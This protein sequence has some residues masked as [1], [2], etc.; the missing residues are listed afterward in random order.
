MTPTDGEKSRLPLTNHRVTDG[1]PLTGAAPS[2]SLAGI[3][4]DAS[5][6]TVARQAIIARNIACVCICGSTGPVGSVNGLG[7]GG[8]AWCEGCPLHYR[9]LRRSMPR[10]RVW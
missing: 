9:S 2:V 8:G 1:R 3:L 4:P 6:L 7:H 5:R 10:V